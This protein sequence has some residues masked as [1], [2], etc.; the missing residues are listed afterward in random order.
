M[1]TRLIT[2]C[3]ALLF[4]CT[5][6][7][8]PS[9]QSRARD[10]KLLV[11][12]VVDQMR[13]DYLDRFKHFWKD[14]FARL[15]ADGA[16]FERA[17]YPYLNTVTC[18]GHATIATG[19]MPFTHGIIMN[20]WWQRSTGTLMA[21]TNDR[22]VKSLSYGGG[23]PE[24]IGHSAFRL[25]LPTLGDRLRAASP[26]SR[27]V[28]M[29]MKPRSA[30]MLTGHGGTAVTWFSD[31]NTWATSTAYTTKLIPEVQAWVTAHPVEN[32]RGAI[33]NRLYDP[34]AYSGVDD[35]VGERPPVGWTPLFA[36][37]LAGVPGTR[38]DRFFDLWERSPFSDTALGSLAATL[39]QS[40]QLGQRGVVDYLGVGFSALD[41]VGHAF[42]PDSQEVQDTLIRLDKALGE[43][44]TVL[45]KSVGRDRYVLALSSDHGVGG[46]PEALRAEG[47]DAGRLASAD[48]HKI[49]EA[50]MVK[51]HGP[52]PH[53]A[54]VEYTQLYLTPRARALAA[55]NPRALD[56]LIKAVS[57]VNGVWRVLSSSG[58]PS[59]RNSSDSLERAA[60]LGY[61]PGESGDVQI[62]LKPNWINTD[63]SAA[64][65][66][67]LHAY[68]QRVPVIF[69]GDPIQR[70]RFSDPASPA[71][72][73]PTLASLV[74]LD[75]PGVDGKVLKRALK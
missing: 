73:A 65:H 20:E 2:A 57:S 50:A 37:P 22:D 34:N 52:G 3:A 39:V 12:V 16:V 59:K 55:S 40:M 38:R 42:G 48:L 15:L 31:S 71:D 46:I 44:L 28:T 61:F 26:Q 21:C 51:A 47:Q 36:H 62:V 7:P 67:S 5:I 63:S 4:V 41:Y 30:V 17:A 64:T 70:G 14:G 25:R 69:Y 74:K 68:D 6:T 8:S 11:I 9:A 32:E 23:T 10:G 53:V 33:W 45:D 72:I 49:A 18:V 19:A 66:G 24:S 54:H 58:L 13:F 29:S 1:T 56:P 75:L 43:F 35:G 60:A 27:V